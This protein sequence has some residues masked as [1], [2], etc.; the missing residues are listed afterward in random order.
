VNF[1]DLVAKLNG[2]RKHRIFSENR[3]SKNQVARRSIRRSCRGTTQQN[4]PAALP[5]Q[6][7]QQIASDSSHHDATGSLTTSPACG[8]MIAVFNAAAISSGCASSIEDGVT[9]DGYPKVIFFSTSSQRCGKK[10]P[11]LAIISD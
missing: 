2:P 10:S 8:E 11:Q 5:H 9:C 4:Y 6:S 7:I 1:G 3:R